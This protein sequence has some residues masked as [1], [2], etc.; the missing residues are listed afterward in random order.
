MNGPVPRE[1]A[2]KSFRE[3]VELNIDYKSE[4]NPQQLAAVTQPTAATP[5]Q[6]EARTQLAAK[7]E[8]H[9]EVPL[10]PAPAAFAMAS[11]MLS[12]RE[13]VT[14]SKASLTLD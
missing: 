2:L 8:E 7:A 11:C 3:P 4:L 14:F 10:P 5:L 9:H 1:Y 13:E 12:V 6:A